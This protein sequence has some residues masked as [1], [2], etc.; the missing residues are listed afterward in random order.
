MKKRIAPSAV[1]FAVIVVALLG[2]AGVREWGVLNPAI[3]T[4]LSG[5]GAIRSTS[6]DA[7]PGDALRPTLDPHLRVVTMQ[8]GNHSRSPVTLRSVRVVRPL[9]EN[10]G[11]ANTGP[12]PKVVALSGDAQAS[13]LLTEL[14]LDRLAVKID[15][16][17]TLN[18]RAHIWVDA[19]TEE[20][21]PGMSLRYSLV[22]DLRTESG[23][24]KTVGRD[25]TFT[26]SDPSCNAFPLPAAGGD[27]SDAPQPADPKAARAEIAA[28][29]SIVY[30]FS[31]PVAGRL[32][33]IDDPRGV[34]EATRDVASGQF[35]SSAL[36]SSARV[37]AVDFTSPD[38]ARVAYE[39]RVNGTPMFGTRR[40]AARLVD[41][42]WKVSRATVCADLALADGRC[43]SESPPPAMPGS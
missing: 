31:K 25:S 6:G 22:A 14:D 23:R 39:L 10:A 42:T 27:S 11:S 32:A 35:G 43:P 34:E 18:L 16:G 1:A 36:N 40:G 20:V 15:P 4:S 37:L 9:A 38:T 2:L 21:S 3:S 30:D 24:T 29:Y 26:T 17:A 7:S 5:D 41:G 8:I 13:G 33:H 19:C 28:A 12:L